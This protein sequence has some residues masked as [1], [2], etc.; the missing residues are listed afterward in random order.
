MSE[1]THNKYPK[2]TALLK[3]IKRVLA[4][5]RRLN[6]FSLQEQANELGMSEGTLENK[7]KPTSINDFTM[8]ELLHI[9]DLTGDF[10]ILT[11]LVA[12]HGGTL[13]HEKKTNIIDEDKD[14]LL[15][16][17]KKIEDEINNVRKIINNDSPT[18]GFVAN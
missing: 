2:D 12:K 14:E 3:V 16:K 11:Y 13:L 9:I 7:L 6:E 8:S 17:I 10:E 15:N 18:V 5:D 4:R 1:Y